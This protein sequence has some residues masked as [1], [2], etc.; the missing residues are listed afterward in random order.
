MYKI[1]SRDKPNAV[2]WNS[3]TEKVLARFKDGFFET[4]DSCTANKLKNLG[5]EIS[6]EVTPGKRAKNGKA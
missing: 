5:Y 1:R 6:S 2:V 3:K 4:E